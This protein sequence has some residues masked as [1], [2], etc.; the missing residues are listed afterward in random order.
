MKRFASVLILAFLMITVLMIVKFNVV[1][2]EAWTGTIHIRADGRIEPS[3]APIQTSDNITYTLTDNVT[4]YGDGIIVERDNIIL[5]GAG[6]TVQGSVLYNGVHLGNRVNVTVRN[7]KIKDF[8]CGIYL[9]SS[10]NNSVVESNIT[11]NYYGID[12]HYAS[13]NNSFVGNK[14]TNNRYRGISLY[15]SSNN[16]IIGNEII[17]SQHGINLGYSSN[18]SI[19]GNDIVNSRVGIY[20]DGFPNNIIYHNNFINNTY[21]A[22]SYKP[23]IWDNGYP[24]GGNFWS[25][26]NGTDAN[27]DGIGDTPYIINADNKDNYPL[28]HP[29]GS[30]VNLNTNLTYLTIQSA[31]N[32]PET[33]NGHT[34][35]V[36]AGSY[37]E[38][39][40]VNKSLMLI[41]EERQAIIDGNKT[42]TVVSITAN[43]VTITGFTIRNGS[44]SSGIGIWLNLVSYCNITKNKIINNWE[45]IQIY[46]STNNIIM[47]NN[48]TNNQHG[49]WIVGS[50]DNIISG[51]DVTENID[52][53][54]HLEYSSNNIISGNN[55]T[56]NTLYG[57]TLKGSSGN[58]ISE[59][60]LTNNWCGIW[61]DG[62][63]GNSISKNK[64]ANNSRGI[65]LDYSQLNNI[66]E[67]LI[68]NNEWGI[69]LTGYSGNP[70]SIY[71][72]SFVDN[73]KQASVAIGYL[74]VW[75]D[76]Y[77]S[78][79]NYWSDYTGVDFYS[80]PYQNET[81]SDGIGDTPYIIDTNNQDRY[82]LM[83]PY[84]TQTY[85]LTITATVGG[86][87]DPPPG[88]YTYA[89][90]TQ[91][92][93]TAIPDTGYSF[94][95]WLLNGESKTENP[96]TITMDN[97]Y[98]LEAKF[99]DKIPPEIS[100]PVQ[101]PPEDVQPGQEVHVW[102]NVTDF[103]TGIKNVTLWYSL[104][105]GIDWI[106]VNM[107][108]YREIYEAL[109]G[110][111]IQGYGN[112]TW[113]TYKIVAY[114]NAEN[115]AV[116][117]NN[118]YYYQYHVIPEFPSTALTLVI[119][120]LM[121]LTATVIL[122]IKRRHRFT[123][124]KILTS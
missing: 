32:A 1:P 40:V 121:T 117:D 17:N 31:I 44:D 95:Y 38:N 36:K 55:I 77:P 124:S 71:H 28:M 11:N 43:N 90:G 62:S 56:A 63:S 65:A 51:N 29:Y 2:S 101:D 89:A 42:G 12:L 37:Y 14:I 80:G 59:N 78:G 70:N 76:E 118:G 102:V 87:T 58:N 119:L 94:D 84:G 120:T 39:I 27:R 123:G 99:I 19:I 45:G 9:H 33:L 8:N 24:S 109:W 96:I 25:D 60:H 105:N 86:T 93:V 57:I 26:Y 85:K 79:G 16:S 53:G 61:L 54:V 13:H 10:W 35:F 106:I 49:V 21:Q 46:S 72:N 7:I 64:I 82:P 111:T 75:D 48:I 107:T 3:G 34:I 114:D 110:G 116:K 50:S 104:N 98:T 81:G 6:Y 91:L 108:P 103:G 4:S 52:C 5:D 112:C 68:A 92:N 122:R 67:N 22:I 47:T 18:N 30:I 115:V 23:N 97:N 100:D 73:T 66:T 20:I 15:Y 88:T 83:Y 41:G 74:N 69:L 113:V